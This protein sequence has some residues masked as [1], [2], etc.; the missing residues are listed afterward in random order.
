MLLNLLNFNYLQSFSAASGLLSFD[1]YALL[2]GFVFAVMMLAP[3]VYNYYRQYDRYSFVM[4]NARKSEV[5]T[6]LEEAHEM[7]HFKPVLQR[8][9]M[10]TLQDSL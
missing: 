5:A 9:R 1:N 4:R 10:I 8:S 6:S 7:K 2:L 3:A